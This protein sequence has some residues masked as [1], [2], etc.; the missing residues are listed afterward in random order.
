MRRPWYLA[1]GE[2]RSPAGAARGVVRT[3]GR[4]PPNSNGCIPH[5][6]RL[7]LLLNVRLADCRIF[8]PVLA[9]VA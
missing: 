9:P 7:L 4:S 1:L 3:L 8:Q 2:V 5:L 6:Q